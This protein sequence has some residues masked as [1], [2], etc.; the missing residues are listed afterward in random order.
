MDFAE[1]SHGFTISFTLLRGKPVKFYSSTESLSLL[2]FLFQGGQKV[3]GDL[4]KLI[5]RGLSIL[6][7]VLRP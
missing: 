5:S 2:H 3:Y 7:R 1:V 4:I 6:L